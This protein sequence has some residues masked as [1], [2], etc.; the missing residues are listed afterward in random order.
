MIN[1]EFNKISKEDLEKINEED[2][3]FITNP[4]RMGDVDGS[5]FIIKNNSKYKFYRVDGWYDNKC[6]IT[7]QDMFKVFPLWKEAWDS[8][9]DNTSSKYV[10]IPMGF[11]NGLCV[12]KKVYDNY[13]PYLL[14]EVK[15]QDTYIEDDNNKYNPCL[16]YPC[17][18]IA[19]EKMVE[20]D[21]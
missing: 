17:W 15:K 19:M 13:Y 5:Y 7:I 12:D 18:E 8:N 2:L 3:M 21:K 1:I 10:F 6:D 14:E 9:I 16:N 11:G 20:E 4:G